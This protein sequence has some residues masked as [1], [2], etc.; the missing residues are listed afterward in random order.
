MIK[1]TLGSQ[2]IHMLE[3]IQ[4]FG[5]RNLA[6]FTL[7]LSLSSLH[8]SVAARADCGTLKTPKN[9]NLKLKGTLSGSLATFTCN[10]GYRLKG[11]LHRQCSPDGIWSGIHPKC[12]KL[13]E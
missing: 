7:H 3:I 13:K 8:H 2:V 5:I 9:G 1:V 6:I 4:E 10:K 11:S 12:G